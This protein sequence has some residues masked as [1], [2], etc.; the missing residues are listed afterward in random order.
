[1]GKSLLKPIVTPTFDFPMAVPPC[2]LI[3]WKEK[4]W[5]KVLRDKLI[6]RR[7]CVRIISTFI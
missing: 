3:F 4:E 5:V 7:G 6:E 1:M 2:D